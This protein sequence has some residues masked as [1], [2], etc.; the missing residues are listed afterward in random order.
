M[1][2]RVAAEGGAGGD[3][4]LLG[5]ATKAGKTLAEAM[6]KGSPAAAGM[7]QRHKAGKEGDRQ[8]DQLK[9]NAMILREIR[10]G[11]RELVWAPVEIAP[12]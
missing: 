12:A 7:I 1:R 9:K 10:D 5:G 6:E 4:G 8:I 3:L 2:N 11:V